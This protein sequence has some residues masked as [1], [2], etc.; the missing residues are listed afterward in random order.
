[1]VHDRK[2]IV[3]PN[4]FRDY[5]SF[6]G[7]INLQGDIYDS[8][9]NILDLSTITFIEP[10]SMVCLLLMG[11]NHLRSTGNKLRLVNIPLNIHQYLY[12][13]D[14]LKK[15][16]FETDDIPGKYLLKRSSFSKS[17]I[18]IIDIPNKERD[19]IKAIS[20]VINIFRKR[21]L[22]ILKY[23]MSDN[24]IDYFVTVISEIC[25]NIFEHS[26]DS[27]YVAMQTYAFGNE[28]TVRLVISDS[29]I[30]IRESLSLRK[31][32]SFETSASYIEM[33]LTTPISSKRQFGYGLCQ[34]NSIIERLRGGIYIRSG[35]ASIS[36]L[37]NK[38]TVNKFQTFSKNNLKPFQ[39]TQ[40]SISLSG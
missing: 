38:K 20:N 14:F 11:R 34:V 25:Q 39:G 37:Y 28:H 29:G 33:A 19:S 23:W 35:D 3:I 31:D 26:L 27:G 24:V 8:G 40:I 36:R 21:A 17:V 4:Y 2:N 5:Y 16:I 7:I 22:F 18:E 13:M 10:Y 1:L 15:G 32:I 12:R 30:G 6:E 9:S